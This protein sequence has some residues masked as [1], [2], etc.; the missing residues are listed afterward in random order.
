MLFIVGHYS[1]EL[2]NY[3]YRVARESKY[4]EYLKIYP[5]LAKIILKYGT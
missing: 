2:A 5:Y 4:Q 3:E 1:D